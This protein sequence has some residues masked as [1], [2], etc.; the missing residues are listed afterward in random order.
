MRETNL[1]RSENTLQV[2]YA[3]LLTGDSVFGL[4]TPPAA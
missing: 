4:W 2:L 1:L 3:V